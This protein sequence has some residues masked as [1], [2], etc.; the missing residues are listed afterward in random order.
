MHNCPD[1]GTP[2]DGTLKRCAC[3][4]MVR[5]G[6]SARRSREGRSLRRK[7]G[8]AVLLALL[9]PAAYCVA[10]WFE[11]GSDVFEHFFGNHVAVNCRVGGDPGRVTVGPGRPGA[12]SC[13]FTNHGF[14]SRSTCVVATLIPLEDAAATPWVSYE[15]CSG[16]VA[17]DAT[18]SAPLKFPT[19]P[20][21]PR[22]EGCYRTHS[23]RHCFLR[24]DV[25][26]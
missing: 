4:R 5:E 2:L 1:C 10:F 24:V 14:F 22:G 18:L 11:N 7:V 17:V 21:D 26:K 8:V 16:S 6:F 9:G 15:V 25:T 12:W 3:G 20:P 23:S 19:P 13:A